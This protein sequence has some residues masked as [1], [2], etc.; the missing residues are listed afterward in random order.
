MS[1]RG[2]ALIPGRLV[3][4]T[5]TAMTVDGLD[6]SSLSEGADRLASTVSCTRLA[7]RGLERAR[8]GH[9]SCC[10]GVVELG[11]AALA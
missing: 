8:R 10:S 4:L 2:A 5:P 6:V 11:A 7:G 3:G 1:T 9:T